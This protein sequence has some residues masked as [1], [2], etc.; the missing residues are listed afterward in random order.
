MRCGTSS[1][2]Y[3][4]ANATSASGRHAATQYS[5]MNR[6]NRSRPNRSFQKMLVMNRIVGGAVIRKTC[7]LP[8]SN[9]FF[10][11]TGKMNSTAV[12][13]L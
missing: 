9:C 6:L 11:I 7:Q 10:A 1:I 13:V 8:A 12:C 5:A 4:C 3:D 2:Q